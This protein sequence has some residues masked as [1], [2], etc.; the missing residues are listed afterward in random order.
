MAV[1]GVT[2][3]LDK[4]NGKRCIKDHLEERIDCHKNGTVFS[5]AAC[6][7]R[8]N[9]N[10]CEALEPKLFSVWFGCTHHSN[11]PCQSHQDQAL[12]QLWLIREERPRQSQLKI[13][14]EQGA[15]KSIDIR[16]KME[17]GHTI[18]N[19]A[20]IQFIKMLKAICIHI[21]RV[22]NTL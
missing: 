17:A 9:Q 7:A 13:Q 5:I 21:W 18:K 16:G 2:D 22:R 14:N 8:P 20:I 10:L 1:A 19:G 4:E 6:Q 12:T 11:A 3:H 15:T